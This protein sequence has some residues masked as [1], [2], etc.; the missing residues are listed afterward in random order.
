MSVVSVLGSG[1]LVREGR[2]PR[3]YDVGQIYL[4][5]II[6]IIILLIII[7]IQITNNR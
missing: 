3:G 4:Y 7:V 1:A 2:Y 6:V 5:D